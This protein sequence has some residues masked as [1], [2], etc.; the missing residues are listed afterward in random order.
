MTKRKT[1]IFNWW[2]FYNQMLGNYNFSYN[3]FVKIRKKGKRNK[4]EGNF[5]QKLK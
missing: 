2:F 5:N 1:S 4:I 3:F